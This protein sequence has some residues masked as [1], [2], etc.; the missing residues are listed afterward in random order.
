MPGP[1]STFP[2]PAGSASIRPRA[3]W[4][5]RGTSRWPP[6]PTRSARRR[7]PARTAQAEVDFSVAM[8][9]RAPGETPRVTKPYSE[10]QWQQIL[11]RWRR[12]GR[13]LEAGDVRLSM[14]GE[15]TFVAARRQRGAGVEHRGAR[16]HQARLCRQAR[17]PA[18]R[19]FRQGR[20]AAPRPGQ[21]V[22]GRAGRALGVR[23]LLAHRRRAALA[24]PGPD[25]RGDARASGDRRR[26]SSASRR[27]LCRA[28]GLAA[29][30]RHPRLRGCGALRADRAEAAAGRRSRRQHAC[31]SG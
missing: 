19:A 25:R 6:R 24:R 14:G 23:H 2:A 27:E 4:P 11:D 30:Q 7:S 20:P 1:R 8:Q 5:A 13:R 28:L 29:G 31:R 16:P 22:S 17:T 9:R 10:A 12:R 15:P 3:C 21:V 26:R 18:A